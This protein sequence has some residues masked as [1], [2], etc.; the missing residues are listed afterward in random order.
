MR[1]RDLILPE[2]RIFL[3]LFK[4]MAEKSPKLLLP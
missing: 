4:E 2:D 3:T 1:I